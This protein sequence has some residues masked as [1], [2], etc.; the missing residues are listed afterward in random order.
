MALR[1]NCKAIHPGY[2]FLSE[3]SDF[4]AKVSD[5]GLIFI[6]PP[7]SAI[8]SMGSKSASKIIMEAAGVPCVPGYHGE[9]QSD[10]RLLGEAKSIGYSIVHTYFSQISSIDKGCQWWRWEGNENSQRRIT[11]R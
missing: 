7:S 4:S 3:N 1:S 6:G 2:G 9:D 5:A 11:I 8:K 10:N